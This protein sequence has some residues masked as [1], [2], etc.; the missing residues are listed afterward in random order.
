MSTTGWDIGDRFIG[1]R[2]ECPSP[3]LYNARAFALAVR[4]LA[5]E[6][7]AFGWVQVAR[8]GTGAV[9]GE[10]R[11][12]HSTAPIFQDFL[13]QGPPGADAPCVTRHYPSTLIKLHF[14]DFKLL[15]D[16]RA[17][18]FENAPHACP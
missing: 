7:S 11:G 18:C 9:V 8:N 12:T 10:F 15:A 5:D 2:F 14:A 6:L 16:G 17:T 1:L 13:R 3:E 4:D